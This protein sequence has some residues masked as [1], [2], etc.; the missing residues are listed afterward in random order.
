MGFGSSK[1]GSSSSYDRNVYMT[2]AGKL[3][4]GVFPSSTD[5]GIESPN[6]YN[7]GAWHHMVATQGTN[8]MKLY[9]DGQQV[10]TGPEVSNLAVNGYWRVGGDN[11][12]GRASR[13]SSD[14]FKGS[15]DEA[16]V[17]PRALSLG[18][19]QSHFSKAGGTVANSAPTAAY[20][21]TATG[22]KVSFDGT[23]ST[24]TDGNIASYAWDFGGGNTSTDSKPTYTFATAGDKTVSLTVTDNKGGTNTVT[25]TVHV[26][27]SAPTADFT[28]TVNGKQVSFDGT[29]SSDVDGTIAS[30]AWDFGDGSPVDTTSGVNVS[31]TYAAA[32]AKTVKLTVTDDEGGTS[33]VTT[34]TVTPGNAKPTANFTSTTSDLHADLTSTS[35][36]SDGTIASYAWD[37]GDSTP[38]DT[39]TGATVGHDYTTGGTYSVKLTV[40]DNDGATDTVTK[41]IS[42]SPAGAPTTLASDDFGRTAVSSWGDAV[43]GGPWAKIAGSNTDYGVDS[44]SGAMKTATAGQNRGLSLGT[45][46]AADTDATVQLSLDKVADGGGSTSAVCS[47]Y[48]GTG[49]TAKSYC[50]RVKVT[51][52]GVATLSAVSRTGFTDAAL[53]SFTLPSA[54]VAGSQLKIRF[55]VTGSNHTTLR[56][57]IWLAGG[58]EPGAWQVDTTDA[59]DL[60]PQTAGGFALA[61]TIASS[62]T[63]VPITARWDDLVIT[64]TP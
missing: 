43:L 7:D 59:N 48:T 34:K 20:T 46:S 56:A 6:S 26:D 12:A 15:L 18:E 5:V 11:L 49:T 24:D 37:F 33:L 13:P 16:A 28:S 19:V 54:L 52:A 31:H 17:Y 8:G 14:Y 3:R 58:T 40:T 25:K 22:K 63:N 4:F 61:N 2:N 53:K 64:T 62:S 36:D 60:G 10:A 57:K 35:T 29:P 21:F 44:G 47:R 41:S 45:L 38:V 51:S 32:G 50:A 23:T 9:V 55:Q 39:T 42:V 30:Y 1:T 27:N